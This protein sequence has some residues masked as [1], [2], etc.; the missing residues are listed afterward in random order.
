MSCDQRGVR[1]LVCPEIG[2]LPSSQGTQCRM[3]C[4][5]G[6]MPMLLY[7]SVAM[8]LFC[9]GRNIRRSHVAEGG[10]VLSVW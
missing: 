8:R 9:S 2:P 1:G 4:E 6:N 5:G 7:G 3:A 10:C